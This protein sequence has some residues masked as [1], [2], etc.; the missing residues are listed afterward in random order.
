MLGKRF[1]KRNP[2][3]GGRI[4]CQCW[5]KVPSTGGRITG[6]G[7]ARGIRPPVDGLP[8]N[9]G[10][11]VLQEESVRRWTDYLPMLT[12]SSVHRWTDYWTRFCKRNPSAGGRIACQCWGK[13]FARGIRP[14]VDGLPA[15]VGEK[16]RPP[17]DGLLDKVLQEESVRRWTDYLPMLVKSSV[18]RWTDYWT[19]FCK[20]NPSAGGRITCQCSIN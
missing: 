18:H 5:R 6:Q 20:R 4:A 3:A 12:K 9:V 7:F 10:E 14:P 15:N 16:F 2:S 11:K 1:C 19:R 8:A 13:G 17:V